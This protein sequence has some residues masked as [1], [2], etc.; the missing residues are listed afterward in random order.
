MPTLVAL[1]ACLTAGERCKQIVVVH[2]PDLVSISVPTPRAVGTGDFI[3]AHQALETDGREKQWIVGLA[4]DLEREAVGFERRE[5]EGAIDEGEL[6]IDAERRLTQ[7]TVDLV[8][9]VERETGENK[10]ASVVARTV[11][12]VFHLDV[13][14][15]DEVAGNKTLKYLVPNSVREGLHVGCAIFT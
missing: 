2:C 15:V 14:R 4:L 6:V 1:G 13:V 3:D 10:R 5:V 9:A 11:A 12:V 8:S 7:H